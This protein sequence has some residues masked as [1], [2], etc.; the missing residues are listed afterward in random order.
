[1]KKILFFILAT[2]ASCNVCYSM[3]E[4]S[5]SLPET[6]EKGITFHEEYKILAGR[7]WGKD[8][9]KI[10]FRNNDCVVVGKLGL[11]MDQLCKNQKEAMTVVAQRV[12]SSYKNKTVFIDIIVADEPAHED[13]EM[14][15][16]A[17]MNL[18]GDCYNIIKTTS[19]SWILELNPKEKI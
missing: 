11:I 1:M 8:V 16:D 2:I 6:K 3:E 15:L 13:K 14:F 18:G 17:L 19:N 7:L 10:T 4:T 9:K 5:S 12:L